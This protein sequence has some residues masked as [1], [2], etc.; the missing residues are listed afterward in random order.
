MN[1]RQYKRIDAASDDQFTIS[2]GSAALAVR[3]EDIPKSY[4]PAGRTITPITPFFLLWLSLGLFVT[5]GFALANTISGA[6]FEIVG[7]VFLAISLLFIIYYMVQVQ[8]VG[9]SN[10]T[11]YLSN[12]SSFGYGLLSMFIALVLFFIGYFMLECGEEPLTTSDSTPCDTVFLIFLV[13]L[14]IFAV[15]FLIVTIGYCLFDK[16]PMSYNEFNKKYP[17]EAQLAYRSSNTRPFQ[18]ATRRYYEY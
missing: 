7:I 8:S 18:S 9:T 16:T 13:S 2:K 15:I 5:A 10:G 12:S 14:I 3:Y 1:S 4:F 6:G 17:P 11:M